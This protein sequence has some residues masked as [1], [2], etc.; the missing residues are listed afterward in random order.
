MEKH[1]SQGTRKGFF[2]RTVIFDAD[3]NY[4]E[5]YLQLMVLPVQ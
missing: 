4:I 3:T 2:V 1:A 5:I